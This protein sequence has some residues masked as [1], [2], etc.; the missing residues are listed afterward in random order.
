MYY[1]VLRMDS[2]LSHINR[3][4]RT[5]ARKLYVHA[6]MLF[7]ISLCEALQALSASLLPLVLAVQRRDRAFAFALACGTTRCRGDTFSRNKRKL[8]IIRIKQKKQQKY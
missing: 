4:T 1:V 2:L 5:W 8:S 6:D 3:R 7:E